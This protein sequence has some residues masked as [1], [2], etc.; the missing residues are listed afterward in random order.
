MIARVSACARSRSSSARAPSPARRRAAAAKLTREIAAIRG[1]PLTAT[2]SAR[3]R[4]PPSERRLA[5]RLRR[6]ARQ[7]DRPSGRH[8]VRGRRD[9]FLA[10]SGALIAGRALVDFITI[11]G[12]E[13]G[14]GAAPLVF[15]DHVGL[16][17]KIGFSRV[18]RASPNTGCT[19]R[20]SS[21]ARASWA[22]R[23]GAGR[24]RARLRPGQR[25]PRGAAGHRLH[26]GAA[27]PHQ[28]LPH[29]HHDAN[30]ARARARPGIKSAR[31][32]NYV[33]LRKELLHSRACGE[34]H[35]SLVSADQH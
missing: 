23:S 11:D 2:A 30:V 34:P 27:L 18:Q 14:T 9:D 32:A 26:P 29:R 33:I 12:G 24:V 8:Q 7:R 21:S 13:G 3:P 10:G 1:V 16:P 31:L 5:A 4:T 19:I 6:V 35:P 28:P 17:F 22:S 25:R 15:T 20:S